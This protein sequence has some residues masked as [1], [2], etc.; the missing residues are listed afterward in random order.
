[1][2]SFHLVPVVAK[3][4]AM[5]FDI[6]ART[7]VMQGTYNQGNATRAWVTGEMQIPLSN[8]WSLW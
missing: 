6:K 3:I 2:A 5:G 4:D 7:L 8:K 1:M